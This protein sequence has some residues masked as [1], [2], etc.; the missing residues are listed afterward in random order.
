MISAAKPS[1][2]S[3]RIST[4]Y[5]YDL[6]DSMPEKEY[7]DVTRIASSICNMPIALITLIDNERQWFKSK[8]G[9]DSS[10]SHRDHAFCAHAILNPKDLFI[11]TD[12]KK[13]L[14]FHDNPLVTGD[15][16]VGFYAGVPLVNEKGMP[17][18][19]LCVIDNKP[20][21]LSQVQT[22]TLKAL[23]R[24]VIAY[25]ELRKKNTLLV[26]QKAEIESLNNDLSQ[27]AHVVA[28]DVKSPCSS[29]A[30]SAALLKDTYGST[31]GS[32]MAQ[33]LDMMEETSHAAIRMVDGI[34]RHTQIVTGAEIEKEHFTFNSLMDEVKNL[35]TL[36]TD[37]TIDIV[38]PDLKLYA[39]RYMLLQILVNLVNNAI[40]YNDKPKGI[41]TI[42][43]KDNASHYTISVEDNGPGIRKQYQDKIF[44]MFST[45]GTYDRFNKKGTGIGLSTVKKLVEKLNGTITVTSETGKGS[46]FTFTFS[47]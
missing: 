18:G 21:N 25:F 41:V 39:A 33:I 4:L 5:E 29:L 16:H 34:L 40:K 26:K 7:D 45:L 47:K 2:E 44:E 13:D 19:T 35:I 46:C 22:E 30:M 42:A 12:A 6:L 32:E 31:M 3:E 24:Q 15:P 10:E 8:M 36:T 17:L 23:A 14:R 20:N 1:N 38:T 11:V 37:F 43:A 28:H 9:I 27:F